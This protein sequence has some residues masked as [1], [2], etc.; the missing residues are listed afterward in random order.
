MLLLPIILPLLAGLLVLCFRKN[1][2]IKNIAIISTFVQLCTTLYIIFKISIIGISNFD[3]FYAWLPD[4]GIN[5]SFKIDSISM[6]M[7]LLTNLLSSIIIITGFNREIYKAHLYYALILITQFALNGVFL[8]ANA[9]LF[10]V[11][12]ELTL[13]PLYFIILFWGGDRRQFFTLKFFI[14]TLLGSFFMLFALLYLYWLTPYPH[15]FEFSKLYNLSPSLSTQNWLFWCFFIAFAIKIPLFPFHSW[16]PSTYTTAPI[17]GTMILSGIMLKMGIY[18]I[19]RLLLPILP[20]GVQQWSDFVMILSIA[21]AIYASIIAFKQ[22]D[23]KTI[24]AWSSMAHVGIIGAGIFA[25]NIYSIK[26]VILQM[27]FHGINIIGLLLVADIIEHRTG[28]RNIN[29]LGGIKK[30]SPFLASTFLIIILGSIALPLTNGFIGEFLILLGIFKYNIWFSI[31]AATTI[32][33]GAIYMLYIYQKIML[34][35][36]S[37]SAHN[38]NKLYFSEKAI[39]ILI[40]ILIFLFGVYPKPLFMIIQ[41]L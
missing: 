8:A 25:Q 24:I 11:L 10:Y 17:Q 28:T 31:F 14:Y 34:G 9:F 12:W 3:I 1:I 27:F 20:L 29:E 40:V 2:I 33:T 23:I 30:I 32:I 7:L 13:I 5:L 19:L 36:T 39:L 15:S 16:Q 41:N 38:I 18:G 6:M 26:G 22:N 37:L 35:T 21:G 4:L